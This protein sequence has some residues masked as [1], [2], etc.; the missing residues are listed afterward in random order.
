MLPSFS[1]ART[2]QNTPLNEINIVPMI[3]VILVLLV[4]FMITAP[5]L[6]HAIKLELPQG[7]SEQLSPQ[8]KTVQLSIDAQGQRYWNNQQLSQQQM[9]RAMQQA[10]RQKPHPTIELY[11]DSGVPYAKVNATLQQLVKNQLSQ[12]AFVSDPHTLTT[13]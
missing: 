13:Q 4:V 10:Q 7:S 11:I 2:Q 3:D 9:Q 1:Q 5:L 12:I 6:T 8:L